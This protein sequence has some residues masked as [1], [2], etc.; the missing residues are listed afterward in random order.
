LDLLGD[1]GIGERRQEGEGLE[2][3]ARRKR[4]EEERDIG[5]SSRSWKIPRQSG[6]VHKPSGRC[7]GPPRPSHA[8]AFTLRRGGFFNASVQLVH[9][10]IAF[11]AQGKHAVWFRE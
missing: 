3:P 5:Q 11:L 9:G 10:P 7:G 2:H 8:R 4:K 1:F 6:V